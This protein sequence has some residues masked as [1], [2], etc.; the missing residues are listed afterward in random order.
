MLRRFS[1]DFALFSI[2]LDTALVLATMSLAA[3]VRP[4]LNL[5]PVVKDIVDYQPLPIL[6]YPAFAVIWVICL[7]IFSVYDP[8]RNLRLEDEL[9]SLLTGSILAVVAWAGV[10]FLSYRETSR[11]LFLT[12]ILLMVFSA[13]GWRLA[14]Q[15]ILHY[16]RGR[17]AR[18]QQVLIIG[19]GLVG[20]DL[21]NKLAEHPKARLTLAGFLDDDP[22]KREADPS[23]L[24]SLDHVRQV[25]Q[26]KK[27]DY[28]IL[29]LPRRSYER[30]NRLI[31][32]LH[33]L[34]VRVFVVPD[35]FA[36]TLHHAGIEE[37][38]G[39]PMLDLRAPALS[40][41]QRLVKRA[42]D[43]FLTLLLLPVALPLMALIAVRIRID[44]QGPVLFH[45]ER[46][47][48]NGRLFN[49]VKFRTMVENAEAMKHL[50]EKI[51]EKG[52]LIHKSD[53]DPRVTRWG[54]FL[55]RSSMDELPQIFNI[56]KGEMSWVGPRPEMPYLVEQYEPWQ[57][58]RFSV[59]PGL[60]G[61]WQV[62]GR[63]DKPMHLNTEEDL[64]YI[65]NYSPWL[66]VVILFKTVGAVLSRR[67]AF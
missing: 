24:E 66:D 36:L 26:E 53:A 6:L 62:H 11:V 58:K 17:I 22:Q 64:Y 10:L 27:I 7:L 43:I 34:P 18:P 59:P 41:Y 67:G 49:V 63:S 60:T 23:I 37:F 8:S 57:R 9:A 51:D 3:L 20:K 55:R 32:D 56:L 61:W 31:S 19:A 4:L 47:G 52:R 13:F 46:V 39:I 12:F 21:E 65:Q 38:A 50:V 45:Q 48:E 14:L 1:I 35:Y 2:F 28:V 30:V 25:V 15:S 5:L 29:A 40:D 54:R 42:F 44:S 16:S 33:D